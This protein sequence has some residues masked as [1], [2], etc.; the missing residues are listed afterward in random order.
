MA[1]MRKK[2]IKNTTIDPSEVFEYFFNSWLYGFRILADNIQKDKCNWIKWFIVEFLQKGLPTPNRNQFES[3]AAG[4]E[5][6][7]KSFVADD[8]KESGIDP[9]QKI[10][11]ESFKRWLW[12]D[13][14]LQIC[15]GHKGINIAVSLLVLDEVGFF[16]NSQQVGQ[17]PSFKWSC[18]W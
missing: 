16:D 7:I 10:N 1:M 9:T 15:Y 5:S 13:N 6:K 12:K 11:F 2:N 18:K 3:F 14:T 4:F 8:L 17:Y